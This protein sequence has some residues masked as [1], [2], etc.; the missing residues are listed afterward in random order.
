MV[1]VDPFHGPCDSSMCPRAAA[2]RNG[3][4]GVAMDHCQPDDGVETRSAEPLAPAPDWLDSI[5][6]TRMRQMVRWMLGLSPAQLGIVE[7]TIGTFV[8]ANGS[9]RH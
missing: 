7:A 1:G 8:R 5:P 2:L 3:H 6:D 4:L 9:N